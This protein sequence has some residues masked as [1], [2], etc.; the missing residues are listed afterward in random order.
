M[1]ISCSHILPLASVK[2]RFVKVAR[3]VSQQRRGLFYSLNTLHFLK[4]HFKCLKVVAFTGVLTL[5]WVRSA[6]GLLLLLKYLARAALQSSLLTWT[7]QPSHVHLC[8]R[9]PCV[10]A[11]WSSG[12]LTS[13]LHNLPQ[14]TGVG[15][16]PDTREASRSGAW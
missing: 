2:C 13:P 3:L 16:H 11:H 10:A 12:A 9:Y 14:Q 5:N 15:S 4:K 7:R 6:R 1:L 8:L